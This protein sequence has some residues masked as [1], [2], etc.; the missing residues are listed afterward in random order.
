MREEVSVLE[1]C[2]Q[3]YKFIFLPGG[4]DPGP[5][6]YTIDAKFTASH[7]PS[8]VVW[9]WWFL[10]SEASY[11]RNSDGNHTHF[12]PI[13]RIDLTQM[14]NLREIGR[15][16]SKRRMSDISSPSGVKS[17]LFSNILDDSGKNIFQKCLNA[18][19]KLVKK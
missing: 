14:T 6:N 3:K 8:R 5:K 9:V 1:K 13:R 16:V 18:S 7:I 10:S 19:L 2:K 4:L 17:G 12:C 11:C 15:H